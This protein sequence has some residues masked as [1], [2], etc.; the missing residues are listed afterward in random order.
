MSFIVT[1]TGLLYSIRKP[2]GLS[3]GS[4]NFTLVLV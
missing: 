1:M 4:I 3:G 2:T